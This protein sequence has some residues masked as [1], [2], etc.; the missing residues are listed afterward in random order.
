MRSQHRVEHTSKGTD[1]LVL[2]VE[3]CDDQNENRSN[4]ALAHAYEGFNVSL[5]RHL[6]ILHTQEEAKGE[7]RAKRSG[8][9]MAHQDDTPNDDV[10]AEVL[11]DLIPAYVSFACL[12][13][14]IHTYPELLGDVYGGELPHEET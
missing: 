6:G 9:G 10:R 11:R 14:Y 7:E 1:L 3:H 8:R 12:N 2:L 5:P 13:K 4:A